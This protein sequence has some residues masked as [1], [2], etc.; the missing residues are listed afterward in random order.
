MKDKF[1]YTLTELPECKLDIVITTSGMDTNDVDECIEII[2]E[3][4]LAVAHKCVT[5]HHKATHE[6]F[7]PAFEDMRKQ[8]DGSFLRITECLM[9]N[10]KGDKAAA[11]PYKDWLFSMM[12]CDELFP[13][14][15][16]FNHKPAEEF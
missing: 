11:A 16:Y 10:A 4:Y 12:L 6:V 13:L 15:T 14:V 7:V 1:K 8:G 2:S 5:E 3:N 9:K